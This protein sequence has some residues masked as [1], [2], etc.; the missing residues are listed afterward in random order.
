MKANN[1]LGDTSIT[2]TPDA[3][4]MLKSFESKEITL[5]VVDFSEK[6]LINIK[7]LNSSN[8]T[9]LFLL[10]G[11]FTHVNSHDMDH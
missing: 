7:G 1:L 10:C 11:Q 4:F 9:F 8:W 3:V 2:C 6:K 5:P